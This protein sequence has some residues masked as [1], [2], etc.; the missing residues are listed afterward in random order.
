MRYVVDSKLSPLK[1]YNIEELKKMAKCNIADVFEQYAICDIILT[2]EDSVDFIDFEE[3]CKDYKYFVDVINNNYDCV[4]INMKDKFIM[5][6]MDIEF[7]KNITNFLDLLKI[8]LLVYNFSVVI[9]FDKNSYEF[10]EDTNKF[11]LL[12]NF[13]RNCLKHTTIIGV[14]DIVTCKVLMSAG[15]KKN[16]DFYLCGRVE[17]IYNIKKLPTLNIK[18]NKNICLCVNRKID[19]NDNKYFNACFDDLIKRYK[20]SF[21]LNSNVY[22]FLSLMK[23]EKYSNYNSLYDDNYL[24]DRKYRAGRDVEGLMEE[25]SHSDICIT[26]RLNVYFLAI[27]VNV[28]SVL[29]V[30]NKTEEKIA[31]YHHIPYIKRSLFVKKVKCVNDLIKYVVYDSDKAKERY[32][33]AIKRFIS[34]FIKNDIVFNKIKNK[35]Q[36]SNYFR[37]LL[38]NKYKNNLKLKNFDI[39]VEY[40][41]D[42]VK[43]GFYISSKRKQVWAI[44][45]DIMKSIQDLCE[46]HNINYYMDAG[47][48]LGAIRHKGFIPWD[49]DIDIVMFAKDY[50]KFVEVAEKEL[51]PFIPQDY[52]TSPIIYNMKVR[53]TNTS[54]INETNILFNSY[55]YDQGLFVDVCRLDNVPDNEYDY[56][57][58][59]RHLRL[60]KEE[61]NAKW[62]RWAE[63]ETDDEYLRVESNIVREQ[64]EKVSRQHNDIK[65]ETIAVL[66]NPSGNPF[67]G[68][69]LRKYRS[70]YEDYTMVDFE[71]IKMPMPKGY[72]TILKRLYGDEYMIP[73]N[74]KS[75]HGKMFIEPNYC[76]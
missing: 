58:L 43:C 34:F 15:F 22:E 9:P 5:N 40:F 31:I 2:E 63:Y 75:N 69:E 60:I 76:I 23:K 55:K 1:D 42:E 62:K 4:V 37:T 41:R 28:P 29:V 65:T 73:K 32:N 49:D 14:T 39:P 12:C 68:Q 50:D 66:A 74:I 64:F 30:S 67:K 17:S 24:V 52:H 71:F 27:A 16:E 53:N 72:D 19:E 46:K 36:H 21:S 6:S 26:E 45:L 48:L 7:I 56:R 35:T 38:Y 44:E 47:T 59:V 57:N 70:E 8:K 18:D 61:S 10:I 54:F 3:S 33:I 51:Y 11:E 20:N 25:L 13:I